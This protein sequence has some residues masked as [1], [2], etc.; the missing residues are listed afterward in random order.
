VKGNVNIGGRAK[1]NPLDGGFTQGEVELKAGLNIIFKLGV[2]AK[3]KYQKDFNN[4]IF[5]T[6]LP[7]LSY[8]VVIIGPRVGFGT[9]A[10]FIAAAEGQLLAGAEMELSNAHILLHFVPVQFEDKRLGPLLQARVRGLRVNYVG[11]QNSVYPFPSNV[12]LKS[13]SGIRTWASRRSPP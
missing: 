8:G 7:S 12:A 6:G 4:V 2:D 9:R 5:E 3:L 11:P 13:P 1:W 10:S